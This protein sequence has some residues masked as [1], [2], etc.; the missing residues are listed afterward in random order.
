MSPTGWLR[1]FVSDTTMALVEDNA[2]L[3]SRQFD[4]G[5]AGC[6]ILSVSGSKSCPHRTLVSVIG[7]PIKPS[8]ITSDLVTRFLPTTLGKEVTNELRR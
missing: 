7:N 2:V 5:N 3:A 8:S 1:A 4:I 6:D